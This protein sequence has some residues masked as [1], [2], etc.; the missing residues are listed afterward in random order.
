MDAGQIFIE[1]KNITGLSELQI[2]HLGVARAFQITNI[3][4][5]IFC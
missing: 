2:T 1:D 5:I 4:S 3:F